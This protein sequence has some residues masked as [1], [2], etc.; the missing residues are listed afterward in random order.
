M[1]LIVKSRLPLI[2][3][4]D[5]SSSFNFFL[6]LIGIECPVIYF[7]LSGVVLHFILQSL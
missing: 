7:E 6:I 4:N 3:I 2:G 1:Y 5:G